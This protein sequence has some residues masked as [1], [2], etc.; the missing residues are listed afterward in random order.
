MALSATP[1]QG[2]AALA[3]LQATM[4][5]LNQLLERLLERVPTSSDGR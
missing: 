5:R 1:N 2:P 4:E 3:Q